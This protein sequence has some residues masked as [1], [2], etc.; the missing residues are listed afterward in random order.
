MFSLQ[1]NWWIPVVSLI[2]L[3]VFMALLIKFGTVFTPSSNPDKKK[4]RKITKPFTKPPRVSYHLSYL[5]LH[6]RV[7]VGYLICHARGGSVLLRNG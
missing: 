1:T 3:I 4:N 5:H 6:P 2:A 7:L